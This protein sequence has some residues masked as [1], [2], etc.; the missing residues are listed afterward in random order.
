MI[1]KL[2]ENKRHT[3][4][5]RIKYEK[6]KRYINDLRELPMADREISLPWRDKGVYLITGGA[7][8][9]GFIFA[10][11]IARQSEQ[12][13]LILTGRSALNADQQAE[14]NELQQLGARA[15]Y[16]QVDVTQTEAASELITSITS[17]YGDL[18][19]VIHS[20]GLIKDNYLMSKTNEELT[21]VFAPKVKGLVNV[22]E[23]TEHLALDFFILFSSISSVAG[24]AGQ[25]DYAM[26]NAF[27][28][29]YAAYRNA[30]VTAMYR[31]GQTLSINWPLW[32]EGGM[33]AN[34]EIENMTLK[35][36]GVTPM[37]TKTGI[38]A[39]YTALAFGKDQVI[40]ME[41]IKDMMRK[42]WLK[43]HLLMKCH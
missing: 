5:Q 9:L 11:E 23:A 15:E 31:H 37:R 25:A 2:K 13:V 8:G 33:R 12:P 3:E 20:A 22:D 30:L 34:K 39:L 27:M 18:N 24:S 4:D 26:A 10:K 19:G 16:R 29:S 41:G 28:D 14:L 7:G 32:K 42:S 40:V 1:E 38:Q 43:S 35:N 36:T 6:G 21:Q 17:D